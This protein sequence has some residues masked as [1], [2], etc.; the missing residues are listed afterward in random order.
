M[1]NRHLTALIRLI[2]FS[3]GV[4]LAIL[5]IAFAV[6]HDFRIINYFDIIGLSLFFPGISRGVLSH[7]LSLA[8]MASLYGLLFYMSGKSN[9][10]RRINE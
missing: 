7:V 8:L 1:N 5:A 6:K 2:L 4:H 10:S 3:A 9:S